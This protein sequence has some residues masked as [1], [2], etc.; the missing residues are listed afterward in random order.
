[1][2]TKKGNTPPAPFVKCLLC[3]EIIKVTKWRKHLA[4]FHGIEGNPNF[5]D[6]FVLQKSSS[7]F[8]IKCR[9]CGKIISKKDWEYHLRK[10]HHLKN[11]LKVQ[12]FYVGIETSLEAANKKWYDPQEKKAPTC[13]TVISGPPKAKI[14][15]N[16]ILSN[17][18]KF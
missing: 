18:R 7:N 13:G 17:R 16:P 2:I 8:K 1:M 15:Y 6:Y 14:I 10:E 5:R 11:E 3:D 9:L 4:R 12:D